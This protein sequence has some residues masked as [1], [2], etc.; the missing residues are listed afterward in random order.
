M[1]ERRRAEAVLKGCVICQEQQPFAVGIETTNR[2][3]IGWER[4]EV[5]E[6]NQPGLPREL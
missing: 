6:C 3:H 2:I 4:P 5:A 1:S